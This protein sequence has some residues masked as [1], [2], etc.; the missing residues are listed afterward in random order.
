M[1]AVRDLRR[2][3]ALADELESFVVTSSDRATRRTA[4]ADARALRRA[5]N[6]LKVKR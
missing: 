2:L 4:L 6:V 1:I 5:I 3:E